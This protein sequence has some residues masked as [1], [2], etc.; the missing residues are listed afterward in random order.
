MRRI[1]RDG[2]ILLLSVLCCACVTRGVLAQAPP[3]GAPS[4]VPLVQAVE[5]SSS[6]EDRSLA[7]KLVS[8]FRTAR[9]FSSSKSVSLE[10]PVRLRQFFSISLEYVR[11]ASYP[12]DVSKPIGGKSTWRFKA[13]PITLGYH[14]V[15]PTPT[16]HLVPIV[17]VGLSYYLGHTRDLGDDAV[18]FSDEE[19]A[20]SAPRP[21]FKECYGMG[22]GVQATFGL[23]ADVSRSMFVLAQSRYRYVDGHGLL[24]DRDIRAE[25]DRLDVAIGFGVKL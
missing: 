9:G 20:D 10:I 1:L 4:G 14:Y 17:G 11:V 5:A 13:L 24:G 22:Y 21:S 25:F 6:S 3:S 23:R 2:F 7:S 12:E 19:V 16:P 15:L 8:S 18:L